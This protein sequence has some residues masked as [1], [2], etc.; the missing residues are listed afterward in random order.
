MTSEFCIEDAEKAL[1]AEVSALLAPVGEAG[2]CLSVLLRGS[3]PD[4]HI[5]AIVV[6]PQRNSKPGNS[7]LVFSPLRKREKLITLVFSGATS[8]P[9]FTNLSPNAL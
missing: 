3:T 2:E 7:K 1:E 9:N 4:K 5:P 6:P 8:R